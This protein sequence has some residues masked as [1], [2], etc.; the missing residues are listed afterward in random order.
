[1]VRFRFRISIAFDNGKVGQFPVAEQRDTIMSRF[2]RYSIL[3]LMLVALTAAYFTIERGRRAMSPSAFASSPI[4]SKP[5][6][7]TIAP[8]QI[9]TATFALG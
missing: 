2:R 6:I 1:M 8:K 5:L 3:L 9:A 4:S 7:D